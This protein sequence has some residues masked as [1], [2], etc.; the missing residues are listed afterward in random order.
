MDT[1]IFWD[2]I[3]SYNQQ[4]WGLQ[5]I[6]L[7]LLLWT[8][9]LSY[10][11]IVPWAA[12]LSL[13]LVNLFIGIAFFAWHGTEPIQKLFALPLYLLCGGLFLYESRHSRA[14]PLERPRP[15]QAALLL[16]CLL[17]PLFSALSG[18]AFP[19]AVTHIMPCP[20]ISLS[21]AVYSGY[22][23]KNR[24][25]LALLTVWGLTGIKAVFFDAYEDL[26]LLLCGLYGALSLARTARGFR[27]APVAEGPFT[28][29]LRPGRPRRMIRPCLF[30]RRILY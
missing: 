17:Y 22:R 3:A 5:I 11:Q 23:R 28:G 24:V 20:I 1:Q 14:D 19:A 10:L 4:T 7:A 25:L 30:P 9:T 27:E 8:I 15:L 16:L 6:W 13:G 18:H 12:K 29:A 2:V 21:I 26:V